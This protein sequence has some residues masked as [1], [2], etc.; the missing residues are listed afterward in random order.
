MFRPL[1]RGRLG[2]VLRSGGYRIGH[3]VRGIRCSF[4][5]FGLLCVL[6]AAF[7]CLSV[8]WLVFPGYPHAGVVGTVQALDAVS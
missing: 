7:W 4:R 2:N 1:G 3:L 6:G 5:M 8:C